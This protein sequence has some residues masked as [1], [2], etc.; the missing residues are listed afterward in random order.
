MASCL[1]AGCSS[2]DYLDPTQIGRFQPTPVVNVILDTLGVAEEESPVFEGAEEPRPIDVIP[3]EEDYRFGPG[4]VVRIAIFELFQEGTMFAS[5]FVINESGKMSI[6]EVGLVTAAGLTETELENEL[7]QILSPSLL[8]GPTINVLL[9]SSQR[10]VF[11]ILGQGVPRPS[12]Y[13]LPRYGFRLTDALAVAGSPSQFNVSYIYVSRA[14]TGKEGLLEQAVPEAKQ[15]GVKVRPAVQPEAKLQPVKPAGREPKYPAEEELMEIIAPSAGLP[16]TDGQVLISS[17]E[18][19]TYKELGEVSTSGGGVD[20]SVQG[21]SGREQAGQ[22][23]GE[24]EEPVRVEWIF[25]DGRWVPMQAGPREPEA[26]PT[27]REV[28]IEPERVP[29]YFGWEQIGEAGVQRRVIKIPVDKLLGGDPR[30]DIIIRCGDTITAPVD[31]IGEAWVQGNVSRVGAINITGRP[32]TLKM[33]IAAAGG[34]G[35]L[36]WPKRIEVIRRISKNREETVMVDLDKIAKGIQPDFFIKPHDLVNVGTHPAARPL[37]VVRNAFR[38]TYGFG[39]VYDR[40][41][42]TTRSGRIRLLYD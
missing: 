19:V 6:P 35:P 36:A 28:R 10:R 32:M 15:A 42:L 21:I 24:P 5:D 30:Y 20:G 2:S 39:F 11:T 14:V 1:V 25:K 31:I 37:A 7:K 18:L 13:P 29:E 23:E 8:K 9:Q 12:R 22:L 17:A 33:A 16:G 34:L 26:V 41:F 40:N 3:F 27:G 38:A 4:D